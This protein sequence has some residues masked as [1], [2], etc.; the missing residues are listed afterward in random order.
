[1]SQRAVRQLWELGVAT[2]GDPD[3]AAAVDQVAERYVAGVQ[4]QPVAATVRDLVRV[5]L[6]TGQAGQETVARRLHF[7]LSTLQR[8]LQAEIAYLVGFSNQ[9]N[10]ARPYRRC[11]GRSPGR[12]RK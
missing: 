2:T 6:P 12:L 7:S 10:F 9:R 5:V 8:H 3:I 4:P 11:T 1:M